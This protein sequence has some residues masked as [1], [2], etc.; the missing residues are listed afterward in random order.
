MN[1][2]NQRILITG[3]SRGIGRATAL[4]LADAGAKI[5]VHYNQNRAA[6]DE[7]LQLLAGPGHCVVQ[8]NIA[9]AVAVKQMVDQAANELGGLDCLVNN[10][11]RYF[12]HALTVVDYQTWQDAWQETF[13]VNLMGAANACYCA[14]PHLISAGGGRIINV[15]SRGAYRGEPTAPA[16]GASKAAMNAMSQSLARALAPHNIVVTAV[17]PGFV[18]TDMA[19]DRLA[20]PD[21]DEVRAQSPFNRV[22]KPEDVANVIRF[23]ASPE[24]EWVAGSIIDANGASYF[25]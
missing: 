20:G 6:A 13:Q 18:E 11:G 17:A 9:D 16:Y 8:A 5:A 25:R 3:A 19:A 15:T 22:A 21:G 23:L 14:V 1:L 4:A 24:S 10:V 7:T 2:T 12:D